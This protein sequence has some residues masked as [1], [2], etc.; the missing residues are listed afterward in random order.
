MSNKTKAAGAQAPD[1]PTILDIAD[2]AAIDANDRGWLAGHARAIRT[3]AGNIKS[4][5]WEIGRRLTDC[6]ARVG[7]G[8][9]YAWID[10]EFGWSEKTAENFMNI[11][12][13]GS[14]PKTFSDLPIPLSALYLLARPS[15]MKG[16]RLEI[17]E[18]AEA[19][20]VIKVADVKQA[21]AARKQPAKR[22]KAAKVEE[23]IEA[24]VE[25]TSRRGE[26]HL[27]DLAV[28]RFTIP[29]IS[30]AQFPV[31]ASLMPLL[32]AR[33]VAEL[34]KTHRAIFH[35]IERIREATKAVAPPA[36]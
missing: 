31:P 15:T 21:I 11:Y 36:Q 5:C 10:R 17:I 4:E 3:L 34:Q 35:I 33:A 20:E 13:M 8:N 26:L 7:H 28:A 16:A 6:K 22:T 24:K 19:G 12:K 30:S 27:F 32:A 29:E 14:N 2:L 25:R 18:R 9:W 23:T 1:D